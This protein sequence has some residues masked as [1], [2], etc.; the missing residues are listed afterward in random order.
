M[1]ITETTGFGATT[2][3]SITWINLLGPLNEVVANLSLRS[4]TN[5]R[6]A[7]WVQTGL[8]TTATV[9]VTICTAG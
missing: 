8:T 2:T 1:T 4:I 5:K 7:S 9:S 3:D 6:I